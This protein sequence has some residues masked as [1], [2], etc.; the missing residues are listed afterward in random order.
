MFPNGTDVTLDPR[1]VGTAENAEVLGYKYMDNTV[2]YGNEPGSD[3]TMNV[4]VSTITKV[5]ISD[6]AFAEALVDDGYV[7][8][9]A[10]TGNITGLISRKFVMGETLL[11]PEKPEDVPAKKWNWM[12]RIMRINGKNCLRVG[13]RVLP[14]TI[15]L[16]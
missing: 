1:T 5:D 10:S 13:P 16:R 11:V 14:Y 12:V 7:V 2:L 15:T 9:C 3:V 4:D 6:P 8:L